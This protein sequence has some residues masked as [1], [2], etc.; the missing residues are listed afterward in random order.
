MNNTDANAFDPILKTASQVAQ[1]SLVLSAVICRCSLESGATD[2]DAKA[3]HLRVLD[4]L[5]ALDLWD[6]A[7]PSEAAMLCA[8]LGV[9]DAGVVLRSGWYVEGLAVLAWALNLIGFPKHDEQVNI[10]AVADAVW[11]L[12]KKAA[13]A[14]ATAELRSLSELDACRELL[15]A[16]HVRLRE[17][18]RNQVAN[19]FTPRTERS[20]L[21]AVGYTLTDLT[22]HDNLAVDGKPIVQVTEERLREVLSITSERHRAIIWL[23]GEQP[24]YAEIT[25]DT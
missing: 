16:I 6:E 22:A 11:F 8:P 14:M 7:E 5:T 1:R 24:N 4:W 3:V 25:V 15:Y 2:P 10:Y 13:E 21:D 17:Y 9:L 12:D 20:W 18:A 19:S 23:M